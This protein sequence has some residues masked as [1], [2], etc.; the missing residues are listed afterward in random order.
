MATMIRL[1]YDREGDFLEITFREAKGYFQ[2]IAA[3]IYERVDES[4]NLLGYAVFNLTC[5]DRQ[6][7]TIPL[8]VQQLQSLVQEM[9]A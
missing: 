4:G 1:W 9:R 6:D 8:E 7:L 3:D 5:H 2:E